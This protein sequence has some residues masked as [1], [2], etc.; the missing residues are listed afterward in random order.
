MKKSDINNVIIDDIDI[1]DIETIVS[2]SNPIRKTLQ[3]DDGSDNVVSVSV[4][5][6]EIM[7][8]I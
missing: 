4:V 3:G 5:I 1:V 2:M 7:P 8:F 6:H